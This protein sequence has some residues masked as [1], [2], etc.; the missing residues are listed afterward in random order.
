M[1]LIN[2]SKLYS[3]SL[4]VISHAFSSINLSLLTHSQQ[5]NPLINAKVNRQDNAHMLCTN[6]QQSTVIAIN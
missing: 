3:H 6:C 4:A 2:A 5:I 1:R